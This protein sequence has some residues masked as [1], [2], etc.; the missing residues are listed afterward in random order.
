M[1]TERVAVEDHKTACSIPLTQTLFFLSLS[2][3][4]ILD[5]EPSSGAV[6]SVN[7]ELLLAEEH[8]CVS[9]WA[10]GLRGTTRCRLCGFL[11]FFA[12]SGILKIPQ[13]DPANVR[14]SEQQQV[15]LERP[16]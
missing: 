2:A 8:V 5:N 4:A 1:Q 10:Q 7:N 16:G 11:R 3:S 6:N 12:L 14:R 9:L 15:T 13:G